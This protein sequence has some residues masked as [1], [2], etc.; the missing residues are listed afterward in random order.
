MVCPFASSDGVQYWQKGFPEDYERAI[1]NVP[2]MRVG[3]THTD[4]GA[5]VEFL[6]SDA[7]SYL[8]N[9]T[10]HVDGGTRSF[11]L[12]PWTVKG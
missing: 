6:L 5:V 2:L 8:T 10:I 11:G 9:Q 4:T 1:S 3:D 12:T 7:A